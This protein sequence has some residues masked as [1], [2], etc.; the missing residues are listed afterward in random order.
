MK[1]FVYKS[2]IV[3]IFIFALYHMTFG[4]HINKAEVELTKYFNSDKISLIREKV[5]EEIRNSLEKD[6]I[7]KKEDAKLLN[8]FFSKLSKEL[9][10][11]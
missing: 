3:F 8:D 5:K 4:Y 2:L 11:N 6:R 1:F 7:L 9:N 10:N